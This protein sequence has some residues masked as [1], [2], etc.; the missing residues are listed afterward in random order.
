MSYIK[1][2]LDNGEKINNF[3]KPS[4]KPTFLFLIFFIPLV[5]I[6]C[7]GVIEIT[8]IETVYWTFIISLV[9]VIR[10]IISI[11]VSEYAITNKRVISKLGLIRR[12]V[13]EMNLKSI[14]SVNLK[15]SIIGRIFNYGSINIS[16]RGSSDVIFKDID[17][18]V[19][20][21][22]KIKNNS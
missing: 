20:I 19:E 18:P 8:I 16:G 15:Q 11:Y 21:R 9:V 2:N 7:W 22:K 10:D 12:D 3:T 4:I 14:E 17:S 5:F 13:E 6:I 1:K